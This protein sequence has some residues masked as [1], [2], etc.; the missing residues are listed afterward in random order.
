VLLCGSLHHFCTTIV[1][2]YA[3][4]GSQSTGEKGTS[5][6]LAVNDGPTNVVKLVGGLQMARL[7]VMMATRWSLVGN[8]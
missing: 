4:G 2:V 1:F 7:V 8:A 6:S 5:S 3:K